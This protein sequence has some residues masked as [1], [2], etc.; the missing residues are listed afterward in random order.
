MK[1]IVFGLL[2][3][4]AVVVS[5][6]LFPNVASQSVKIEMM[7]WLFETRTGMF[8][9]LLL[10][11]WAV[12]WLIQKIIFVSVNSPKQFWSSLRSGTG[13]RHEL[14]MQ[15]ALATW[16]DEGAGHSQKLLKKSK[17]VVPDWLYDTLLV[18]LNEPAKHEAMNGEKDS[19]LCIALK[20]RLATDPESTTVFTLS[21]RQLYLDAWLT[22]HP[23]ATLAVQRKASLLGELA[24]YAEQVTLLESLWKKKR[25]DTEICSVYAEALRLLA[26]VQPEGALMHL[27]KAYN[28]APDA[29]D[30]VIDLAQAMI[31]DNDRVRGE[32]ML[33]D[34]LQQH[35]AFQVAEAALQV[36]S[37]A[38]LKNYKL[39]DKPVFQ[40]TVAGSWLRLMLAH[41]ADLVG[42]AEDG[43]QALLQRAPSARLWQTRA[44]WYV[45]KQQWQQAAE[46]YQQALQHE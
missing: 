14:R 39:V 2:L 28:I 30:I 13:K 36:L 17:G 11:L 24:E 31:Q 3:V 12:V 7:G 4:I 15:E 27:R 5:L 41:K 18:W 35:D 40:R 16:V 20:A 29:V 23:H 37:D 44:D 19:P 34:Y 1:R 26:S 9:L 45:E 8:V 42:L 38:P 21:E 10:L 25:N 6:L 33:L 22:A 46:S 32:R 43:M